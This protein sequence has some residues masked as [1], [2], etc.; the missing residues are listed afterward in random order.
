MPPGPEAG[1]F[2]SQ[3]E[4]AMD[5]NAALIELL[6][7]IRDQDEHAARDTLDNI[8]TWMRLGGFAPNTT[9]AIEALK[10]GVST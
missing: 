10:Q 1:R 7:A 8:Q 2:L 4:S 6:E 3:Q 5:P 9:R